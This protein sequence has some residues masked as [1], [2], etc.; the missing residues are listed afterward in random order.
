MSYRDESDKEL[1][2]NLWAAYWLAHR[3]FINASAFADRCAEFRRRFGRDHTPAD[4]EI[5]PRR[6]GED[7]ED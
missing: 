2:R 3:G 6:F 1:C 7:L 4:G 5:P